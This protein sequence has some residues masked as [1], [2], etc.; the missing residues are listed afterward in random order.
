[1]SD[2]PFNSS[3]QSSIAP[4]IHRI[5]TAVIWGIL[6]G[7]CMFV[8]A[9]FAPYNRVVVFNQPVGPF[10][11]VTSARLSQGGYIVISAQFEGGWR[12]VGRSPYLT[13]GYYR[14]ITI[15]VGQETT[16]NG[17][18]KDNVEGNFAPRNFIAMV[19]R[20]NGDPFVFSEREDMPVRDV[21]GREYR[22]PF[23]F[24]GRANFYKK[25]LHTIVSAPITFYTDSLFP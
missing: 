1:M 11:R 5:P 7:A 17:Q 14:D 18:D 23:W 22:K 19:Y 24:E 20:N 13:P 3:A 10:V 2:L 15:E 6:L 16:E 8:F 4:V 25:A 9:V 12:I 21:F